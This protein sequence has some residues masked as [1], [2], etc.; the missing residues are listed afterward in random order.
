M[1][2]S[3]DDYITDAA[4]RMLPI[5][6]LWS[7]PW[8]TPMQFKGCGKDALHGLVENK[9]NVP[10]PSVV[11]TRPDGFPLYIMIHLEFVKS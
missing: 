2:V 1:D 10:G 4:C 9:L 11:A 6:N 3:I 5:G 8:Q 7:I